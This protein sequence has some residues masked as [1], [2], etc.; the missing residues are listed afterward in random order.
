MKSSTIILFVLTICSAA[1][2]YEPT[3]AFIQYLKS[4]EGFRGDVYVCAG[5]YATIGYGHQVKAG[6]AFGRISERQANEL[7]KEDCMAF[8]RQ[9]EA[10]YGN[11]LSQRQYEQLLDYTFNLGSLRQFPKMERAILTNDLSTQR[12]EYKRYVHGK[13]LGRNKVF[14]KY[15]NL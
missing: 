12:R 14:A 9:I 13:P 4:V 1:F 6:E 15:F 8:S 10:K 3:P 5:G 7:L 2:A 11:G